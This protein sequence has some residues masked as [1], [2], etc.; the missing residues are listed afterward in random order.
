[1]AA[2]A[3]FVMAPI[4]H[5]VLAGDEGRRTDD[6]V[7]ARREARPRGRWGLIAGVLFVCVVLAM[8]VVEPLWL[9]TSSREWLYES[10]QSV[11]E[12]TSL[13]LWLVDALALPFLLGGIGL[14]VISGMVLCLAAAAREADL[15]GG[16]TGMSVL[17]IRYYIEPAHS[18]GARL[19]AA[20]VVLAVVAAFV[21][22]AIHVF[23]RAAQTGGWRQRWVQVAVGAFVVGV[24]AKLVDSTPAPLMKAGVEIPLTLREMLGALEEHLELLLPML[25]IAAVAV[26]V[27]SGLRRRASPPRVTTAS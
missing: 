12:R 18:I 13:V 8:A 24:L 26:Y 23:R 25:V 4:S 17:K 22:V 1:M 16:L 27:G 14:S 19:L 9:G 7:R 3:H 20:A 6:V 11:I 10:E 21:M 5:P 2:R 15:H